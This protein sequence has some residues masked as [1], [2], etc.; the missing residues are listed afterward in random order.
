MIQRATPSYLVLACQQRRTHSRRR[1]PQQLSDHIH[2][3]IGIRDGA[4]LAGCIGDEIS[5]AE[6]QDGG[7]QGEQGLGVWQ[8]DGWRRRGGGDGKINEWIEKTL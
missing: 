6:V 5:I 7:E 1:A 2:N 3:R 8:R 4:F